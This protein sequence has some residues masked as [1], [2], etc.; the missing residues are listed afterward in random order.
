MIYAEGQKSSG[1]TEQFL[2]SLQAGKGY[3]GLDRYGQM[4]V[5][6]LASATP[7]DS[8]ETAASWA[9]RTGQAGGVYFIEWYNTHSEGGSPVAILI[10]YGHGTGTGGYV[11]G[12]DYINPTLRPLFDKISNDVWK[13]VTSG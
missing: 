11:A 13:Q 3:T 8:G 5:S 12:V 9:Y 10:Q 6:A 4:G 1:K 2:E 7:K